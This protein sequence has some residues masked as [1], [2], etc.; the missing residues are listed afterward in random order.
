[1]IITPTYTANVTNNAPA[2]FIPCAQRVIDFLQSNYINPVSI[3][4]TIDYAAIADNGQT[5]ESFVFPTYAQLRAALSAK[6]VTTNAIAAV[7]SLP[8]SDFTGGQICDVTQPMA[9]ALGLAVSP[10]AVTS[11][12]RSTATWTT[13]NSGGV[14]PGTFDLQGT[15][16]HEFTE[17][18]GRVRAASV[19]E[20]APLDLFA[21]T[22]PATRTVNARGGY[23][24]IDNGTTNLSTP[25]LFA[26]SGDGGDWNGAA[27]D[28]CNSS[29]TTG[30][31]KP[32]SEYDRI[33]MDI[34]GWQRTLNPNQVGKGLS[35]FSG[36]SG[37]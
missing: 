3:A 8:G 10:G 1:M 25:N 4:I 29:G 15:M 18:M 13:D 11:T 17:A 37:F 16:F 12:F 20:Y 26:S 28:A 9:F 33:I 27:V 36:H 19:G 35:G 34:L 30:V 2:G 6:A 21:Y 24:S 31:V 23:F 22:A 5:S 7:A 14:A 32:F